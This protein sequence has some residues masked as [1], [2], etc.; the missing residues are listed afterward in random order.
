MGSLLDGKPETF[1]FL[2][3]D[4]PLPPS[5]PFNHDCPKQSGITIFQAGR[6]SHYIDPPPPHL[7]PNQSKFFLYHLYVRGGKEHSHMPI[8]TPNH[9]HCPKQS[10]SQFFTMGNIYQHAQSVC[11]IIPTSCHMLNL[12]TVLIHRWLEY[13][14]TGSTPTPATE[15]ENDNGKHSGL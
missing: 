1:S 11:H 13:M 10:G 12:S 14:C 9:N 5:P 7:P 3:T 8:I 6:H 15:A 2:C 4:P